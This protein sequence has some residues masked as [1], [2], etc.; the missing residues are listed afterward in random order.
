[1]M[2]DKES[3][4]LVVPELVNIMFL[5]I[6]AIQMYIGIEISHPVYQVRCY[7]KHIYKM[8]HFS[9]GFIRESVTLVCI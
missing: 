5:S 1:M 7:L 3:F 4:C 9:Q 6:V 2:C 8:C